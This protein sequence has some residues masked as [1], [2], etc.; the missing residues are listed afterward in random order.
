VRTHTYTYIYIY[1]HGTKG[2]DY[3]LTEIEI[4]SGMEI[5]VYK[6][7]VTTVSTQPSP[8]HIFINQKQLQ[9]V[10]YF[11]YFG[12]IISVVGDVRPKLSP[13]LPWQK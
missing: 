7:K 11:K 8:K 4:C 12:S 10:E 1:I 13:G 9:N 6:T 3:I 2:H 5:N